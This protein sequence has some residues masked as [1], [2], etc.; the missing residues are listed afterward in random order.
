M[1]HLTEAAIRANMLVHCLGWRVWVS[2]SGRGAEHN[3]VGCGGALCVFNL[4]MRTT[5][6]GLCFCV[7]RLVGL[8]VCFRSVGDHFRC[9]VVWLLWL[10]FQS[11]IVDVVGCHDIVVSLLCVCWSTTP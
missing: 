3:A 4:R 5:C 2:P 1:R 10:L 8:R 11:V 6:C 7:G 9:E